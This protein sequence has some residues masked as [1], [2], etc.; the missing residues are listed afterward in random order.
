[1]NYS[2]KED[3]KSLTHITNKKIISLADSQ[4]IYYII[5]RY[6]SEHNRDQS[7]IKIK[8]IVS[9]RFLE[10]LENFNFNEGTG[11]STEYFL[12]CFT[13][14]DPQEDFQTVNN[15]MYS[16]L[17]DPFKKWVEAKTSFFDG[18]ID[19]IKE[20]NDYVFI[21]RR[22]D[23]EGLYAPGKSTYTYAEALLS[24]GESVWIIALYGTDDKFLS[25][26]KQYPKLKVSVLIGGNLDV[27]LISVIEI[28]KLAKPK[29]I[30][31][32][33]EFDLPSVLAIINKKIPMFYLSQGYY[34]LPW[35]D[36]IGYLNPEYRR[37]NL[38]EKHVGRQEIDFFDLPVWVSRD[39]LA[40]KCDS[41]AVTTVRTEL[42]LTGEDFVIG[43]FAQMGKFTKPF[44]SFLKLIL[45]K[46]TR[47]KVILAGP[48]DNSLVQAEL[49]EFIAQNRA[50]ILPTVDVNIVGHCLD[51]GLDSFPL[52][53]GYSVLEL[54]AKDIPVLSLKGGDIGF[55]ERDRLPETVMSTE[56]EL[57]NSI[58]DL[59]H[60]PGAL[61][62]LKSKTDEFM[63][64]HEKS[65]L[66]LKA[67]E[68]AVDKAKGIIF[69]KQLKMELNRMKM[70]IED[71]KLG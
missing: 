23:V 19:T 68:D 28:L 64:S 52:H 1:M 55:V 40:P 6:F 71:N 54:M 11:F 38:G 47:V 8:A 50:L 56:T 30:L 9:E 44:L 4:E 31:T 57:A 21:V 65:E 14:T 46:E 12:F 45:T 69:H 35:Y 60:V 26:T 49:Q 29:V 22:I 2:V 61:S 7:F 66:F 25:L 33:T 16:L 17:A 18:L 5:K 51:I 42:G 67:L 43:S 53:G 63:I 3:L 15:N 58:S 70:Q 13:L 24:R 41:A 27:R 32:E 39:I 34:N 62:D 48:N 20:G 36:L 59:I 10:I 37:I